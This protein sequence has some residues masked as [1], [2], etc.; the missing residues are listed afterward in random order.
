[1]HNSMTLRIPSLFVFTLL[2]ILGSTYALERNSSDDPTAPSTPGIELAKLED[3][4][5]RLTAKNVTVKALID[6]VAAQ[7]GVAIETDEALA[8]Q[9]VS[10]DETHGDLEALIQSI[11]DSNAIVFERQGDEIR[12]VSAFVTSQQ[13]EI[14]PAAVEAPELADDDGAAPRLV[15]GYKL[16]NLRSKDEAGKLNKQHVLAL[17]NALI[18]TTR[19]RRGVGIQVP[20]ALQAREDARWHIVQFDGKVTDADR[21]ALEDA[22]FKIGHY[23]PMNAVAVQADPSRLDQLRNLPGVYHVEAYHPYLK[24]SGDILGYLSGEAPDEVKSK[25][26]AGQITMLTQPH[27]GDLSGIAGLAEIE[28]ESL[29]DGRKM[30]RATA[31]PDA[32]VALAQQDAVQWMEVTPVFKSMNDLGN[33]RLRANAIKRRLPS[34]TGTGVVVAVTDSGIDFTHP[35]FA[36]NPESPTGNGLNSRV[37]RYENRPSITSDGFPGDT[38]G[39]G[40]HV[41]G[42]ILGNGFLST[43]VISAPGSKGPPYTNLFGRQ[44]A[45]IAPG[46][47]AVIIEDFN[48][49][50]P[51]EQVSIAWSNQARIANNSWGASVYEY[52]ADSAAWDALVRDALPGVFGQQEFTAFF[53]AGNDGGGT[54][55]GLNG[56]A[57]TI[58]IPANAKNVI[59]IGALEQPRLAENLTAFASRERSDSDWQVA[60]FSS[61]GPVDVDDD[62]TQLDDVRTKPDLVAPG[63]YVLSTQS[64]ETNPDVLNE[65]FDI[66]WDYRSGNIDSGTN[67]AFFSGTSMASPLAAGVGA[68]YIEYYK[69]TFGKNPSPAMVKAALVGGARNVNTLIYKHPENPAIITRTVDQGWGLIDGARSIFGTGIHPT[70][71]LI[72]V[73]QEAAL[74]TGQFYSRQITVNPGEGGLKIVLAWTDAP[75]NPAIERQLVN[76]LDLLVLAPG[77]GGY[78]GNRFAENG[79]HSERFILA[80]PDEGDPYNNVE[81]ILI[82]EATPGTYTIR[83]YGNDVP[84]GPQDFAMFI[85]K[86]VGQ[87]R[88]FE[89]N[90]AAIAIDNKGR[91]HVAFSG[92]DTAGSRQVFVK[93]WRGDKIGRASCRERV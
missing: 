36:L 9:V 88:R 56:E 32:L 35:D 80:S 1:M 55:D 89:G 68:L 33:Q 45:G 8:N 29:L 87:E 63:V 91:P 5:Y 10:V 42:S 43:S 73:D 60:D 40:T 86:G 15:M 11:S 28:S 75:G 12:L 47:K 46:A 22:G 84:Q 61:R 24:V 92:L 71:Q 66:Q 3:G 2:L 25:V 34:L 13:E 65:P 64:R 44:F 51:A 59:T 41:A 74:T 90:K 18:D 76:N 70:D 52:T 20:A 93:Q 83:A 16:T 82:P 17:R 53:A 26:E 85:M 31:T 48:S 7:T 4:G 30:I 37:V 69:N 50:T 54:P 72:I 81:V 67:Y 79:V 58:G 49:F 23:V 19:A 6:H 77:G 78:V 39:H 57:A 21:K 62:A 27:E 14:V 38:D